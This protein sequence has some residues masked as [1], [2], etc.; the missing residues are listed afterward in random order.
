[1]KLEELMGSLRTFEMN[2]EEEKCDKKSK[3]IAFQVENQEEQ[4]EAFCDEDDDL[5][6][7]MAILS[8]NFSKALNKF[9]R[10][11]KAVR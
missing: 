6:E 4:I 1:M 2:L 8:K 7:T 5:A 11:N 3:G 10:N 9:N